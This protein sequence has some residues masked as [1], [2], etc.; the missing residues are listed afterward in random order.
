VATQKEIAVIGL[1]GAL[2]GALIA[3]ATSAF[4]SRLETRRELRIEAAKGAREIQER[5]VNEFSDLSSVAIEMLSRGTSSED[6][7]ATRA[8]LP[9]LQAH[10]SRLSLLTSPD[11]AEK[12]TQLTVVLSGLGAITQ[13]KQREVSQ[14]QAAALLGQT[15]AMIYEEVADY[16]AKAIPSED[17]IKKLVSIFQAFAMIQAQ[18]G[19]SK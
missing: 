12:I 3:G 10:A 15:Q 9:K 14:N 4:S 1:V 7:K 19:T 6:R 11:A 17:E 2:S 16:R 8:A 5:V 18:V 13:P